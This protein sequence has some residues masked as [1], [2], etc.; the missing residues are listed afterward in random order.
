M[1]QGAMYLR[2]ARHLNKFIYTLSSDLFYEPL[3]VKYS[4]RQDY[5]SI[6]ID[7]LESMASDWVVTREGFW[8]HVHPSQPYT[9][10]R[11]GWKVHVSATITMR[12]PF[13]QMT[14]SM[15][16]KPYSDASA[17]CATC[18]LPLPRLGS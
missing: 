9:L 14:R 15:S 7:L 11:Q 17:S 8:F 3:E 5:K 6:V 1:K 10:P 2:D 12:V 18:S 16:C 13:R 4:P